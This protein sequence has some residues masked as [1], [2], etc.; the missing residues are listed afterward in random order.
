MGEWVPCDP[1]PV[2]YVE[3]GGRL[4]L[5]KKREIVDGCQLY[6]RNKHRFFRPIYGLIPH[7]Y[8]C[9]VLKQE[10]IDWARENRRSE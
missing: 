4:K 10:R 5:F 3:G 9:P 8:T 7:Y 1:D 6:N 2:L